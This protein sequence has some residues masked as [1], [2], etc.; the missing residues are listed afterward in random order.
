MVGLEAYADSLMT[1]NSAKLRPWR[2]YRMRIHHGP[3]IDLEMPH[4]QLDEGQL[5]YIDAH[6]RESAYRAAF[7]EW[8]GA[9]PG[10]YQVCFS[11]VA[12]IISR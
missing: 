12:E 7:I 8:V 1:T 9:N 2:A 5:V 11:D 3:R 4:Q 10:E 6:D